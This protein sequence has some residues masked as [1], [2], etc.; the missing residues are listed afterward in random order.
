MKCCF[1][2]LNVCLVGFWTLG[3]IGITYWN[4]Y[5][6]IQQIVYR[7]LQWLCKRHDPLDTRSQLFDLELSDKLLRTFS[8][9]LRWSLVWRVISQGQILK[10]TTNLLILGLIFR[11]VIIAVIAIL[12]KSYEQTGLGKN[13]FGKHCG[14]F[15]WKT[16]VEYRF[17]WFFQLLASELKV[18]S[19]SLTKVQFSPNPNNLTLIA[20]K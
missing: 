20:I 15:A 6:K 5:V 8:E 16:S 17:C 12:R 4:Y 10:I 3:V 7:F 13:I 14:D 18:I 19:C 11:T 9:N 1:D 2:I